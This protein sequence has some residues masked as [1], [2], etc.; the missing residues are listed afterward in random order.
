MN[1]N[2]ELNTITVLNKEY[3]IKCP[4]EKVQQLHQAAACLDQEM[5]KL[6]QKSHQNNEEL[7]VVA[8]LNVCNEYLQLKNQQNQGTN[9][10]MLRA[11]GLRKKIENFLAT[12]E[13]IAL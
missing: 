3:R 8:A 1:S 6:Q 5:Q 10:I 9:A 2:D 4:P 13:E 11:Q 12:S 7:A